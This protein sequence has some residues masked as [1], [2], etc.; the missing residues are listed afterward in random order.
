ML[1]L[2]TWRGKEC[3]SLLRGRQVYEAVFKDKE[4]SEL[5]L[6]GRGGVHLAGRGGARSMRQRCPCGHRSGWEVLGGVVGDFAEGL[7][8]G[9]CG[10]HT[11]QH[12]AEST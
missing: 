12:L 6:E 4:I 3:N 2:R 8:A 7:W 11:A 1:A 5:V 9:A 10:A